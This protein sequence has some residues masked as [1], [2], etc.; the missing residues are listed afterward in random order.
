MPKEGTWWLESKNDPR[1]NITGRGIVGL[2]SR[3]AEADAWVQQCCIRYGNPPE[4]LTFGA[5]KD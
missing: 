5:M 4:D 1:W 3:P 2:F